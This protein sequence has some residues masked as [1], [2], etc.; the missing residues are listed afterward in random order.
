MMHPP[1][2][3]ARAARSRLRYGDG[4]VGT[5]PETVRQAGWRRVLLVCGARSFEASGAAAVLPA[6]EQ[7]AEVR[8]WSDFSP[9]PDSADLLGGLR[10]LRDFAPDAVVGVGGGSAMDM[11][12]LLCAYDGIEE[13]GELLT[14]I[15]SGT[16][17]DSRDRGLALV[18]TTSG[19]GSEATHF[20]VVY[21]GEDKYS[22]AGPALKADRVMLDPLL[23]RSGSAYQRASSGIDAVCQAIESLWAAGATDR[24]RRFARRALGLLLRT[25]EGFVSHGAPEAARA[26]ALGSH[27]AGRAIDISKTT[28]AHALSYAITKRY[29]ISHG[30]AVALTLGR[31]IA[32]H[33]AAAPER[34]QPGMDP[35][36]HRQSMAVILRALGASDGDEGRRV[37]QAFVARLG[38]EHRMD[39]VVPADPAARDQLVRSVNLERLGNNPVV[40]AQQDLA[41]LLAAPDD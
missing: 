23:T 19:S 17:I 29:G 21:I 28:A 32:V 2:T 11:A 33:A 1:C 16:R 10:L 34:L 26:M 27:L 14:A 3:A 9:D 36:F 25:I 37:F 13:S 7:S 39:A 12:K 24:S 40:F 31:F 22:I 8:R 41:A 5:L 38:L 35:Q 20:A 6:L 4:V 30:H 15:R 18:P